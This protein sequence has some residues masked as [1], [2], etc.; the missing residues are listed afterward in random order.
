MEHDLT[1]LL[2]AEEYPLSFHVDLPRL[3]DQTSLIFSVHNSA[4]CIDVNFTYLSSQVEREGDPSIEV[5]ASPYND[6]V[7]MERNKVLVLEN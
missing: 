1:A 5:C 3:W 6:G 2:D 7:I 4:S